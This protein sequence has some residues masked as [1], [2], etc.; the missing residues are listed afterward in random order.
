DKGT[1]RAAFFR[2]EVDRYTWV[3]L[4]SSFVLSDV[5]AAFLWGQ[6][7]EV[8]AITRARLSIWQR[9]HAGLAELEG[10]GLLRRPVIP[11]GVQHNAHMYYLLL[12][13]AL[14]RDEFLAGVRERGVDAVFHYVP[15]H[16][17]PAG[18]R[19]GRAS[20]SLE[21]TDRLSSR[22]VRLPLWTAM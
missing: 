19:C 18:R 1:D 10:E 21:V 9:Y 3:S 17:A 2:G 6:L 11:A 14:D 12:G 16:S 20:G 22:L 8:D 7:E 4:G 15:L 5:S 13:T